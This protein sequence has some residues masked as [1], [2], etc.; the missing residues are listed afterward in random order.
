MLCRFREQRGAPRDAAG[1]GLDRDKA[2][3]ASVRGTWLGEWL[4]KPHG[5]V[6]VAEEAGRFVTARFARRARMP[7]Q[8]VA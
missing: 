8:R 3:L 7:D 1:R 4:V 5:L 6:A 2:A